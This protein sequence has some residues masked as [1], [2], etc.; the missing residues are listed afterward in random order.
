ML[1]SNKHAQNL[2]YEES[3]LLIVLGSR[4]NQ[5][6]TAGF[7]L[8]RPGRPFVHIDADEENIG[9]NSRPE[10]GIVADAKQVLLAALK[11]PAP[12]PNE[13]RASWIAEQHAAQKEFCD[14]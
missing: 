5:Q 4:L 7:T 1:T 10:V 3:D 6:T 14:T 2:A 11:H 8:P 13:S 12:R 9:Q